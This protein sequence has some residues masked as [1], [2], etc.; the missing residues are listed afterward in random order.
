MGL[1]PGKKER[2]LVDMATAVPAL[3]FERRPEAELVIDN[4][5]YLS[6]DGDVLHQKEWH[7]RGKVVDFALM[8]YL[9]DRHPDNYLSASADVAR[10]DTCHSEVHQHQFYRSGRPQDRRVIRPLQHLESLE[11][12]ENAVCDCYDD[13]YVEMADEWEG[14]LDRWKE[15]S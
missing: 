1:N 11:E 10:I 9:T 8:H 13:C 14:H 6:I 7:F 5:V 4:P 2:K 12:A 3:T 15:I